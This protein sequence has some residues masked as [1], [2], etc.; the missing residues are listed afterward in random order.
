MARPFTLAGLLRL[1]TLQ[2]DA[3]AGDLAAANARLHESGARQARARTALGGTPTDPTDTT[4]LYA[5]AAARAASRSMLADLEALR[6]QQAEDAAAA[7]SAFTA[8]RAATVG[9][10]KLEAR[11][12]LAIAADDLHAEQT[13]IDEIA[14]G[15]WH[16]AAAAR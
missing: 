5:V 11:H 8:A 15:S 10:E 6:Q 9:L 14:S 3:A 4:T 16:R 2:Q 13:V 1:R 7:E 12:A